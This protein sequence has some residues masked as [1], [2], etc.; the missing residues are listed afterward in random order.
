[1]NEYIFTLTATS[2]KKVSVK[3]DSLH[4][5]GLLVEEMMCSTDVLDFLQD[6]VITLDVIGKPAEDDDFDCAGSC[7]DCAYFCTDCGCCTLPDG[8]EE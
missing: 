2:V 8:D 6:D 1:M 5:A 4:E 3:A 7:D